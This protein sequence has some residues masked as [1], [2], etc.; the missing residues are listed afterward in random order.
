[1]AAMIGGLSWAENKKEIAMSD[2]FRGV[3]GSAKGVGKVVCLF[4]S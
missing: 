2:G 3:P 1:M 4:C